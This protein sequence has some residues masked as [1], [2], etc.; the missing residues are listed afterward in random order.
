MV[1]TG[2]ADRIPDRIAQLIYLDA[3]V[4]RHGE[5]LNDLAVPE[6]RNQMREAAQ[7]AGDAM[8]LPPRAM[9]P[10][11]SAAD[12]AWSN[13]RRVMQ[14]IGTFE[15]PIR[16][17]GAVEHLRRTYVYCTKARAGDVF[18]QFAERAKSETGWKYREIDAS[19]NPHITVPDELTQ[20]LDELSKGV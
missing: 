3:F 17:S 5:S 9:P 16:L 18:R 20:M 19:H 4:P 6:D 7:K 1:A 10:D 13:P 15:Q 12:L 11:T 14:P 8:R 2:V